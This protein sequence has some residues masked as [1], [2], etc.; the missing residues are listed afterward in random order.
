MN[1]IGKSAVGLEIKPASAKSSGFNQDILK[2]RPA[3]A[4]TAVILFHRHFCHFKDTPPHRQQGACS[5]GRGTS[6]SEKD[7]AASIEN[8]AHWIA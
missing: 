5:D 4:E 8:L 7:V 6:Y 2:Q 3:Y 1:G